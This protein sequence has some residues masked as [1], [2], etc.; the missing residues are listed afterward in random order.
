MQDEEYAINE[1]FQ[2]TALQ[3]A[4]A[5][6]LDE[7]ESARI[8][9]EALG[10]AEILGRPLLESSI[11]RFHQTRK[12][13]LDSFRLIL[14]AS[15]DVNIPESIRDVLL[16]VII[17]V[18]PQDS[19]G[20]G[21][22]F[23]SKCLQKMGEMKSMLQSLTDRLNGA[24]VLGQIQRSEFHETIEYQRAS[25]V[26]QHESLG[27]IVHYLVK[28]NHA[29]PKDFAQ[30]LDIL[31]RADKYDNLLGESRFYVIGCRV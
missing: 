6:D 8:A 15:I 28:A 19:S 3:L 14:Y 27:I 30:I 21:Q 22:S 7:I 2:Q 5:L 1:D 9:L 23:V 25:L 13:L 10:D 20:A 18:L 31:K 16:G 26:Q 12:Y 17:R 24:S 4:D 29:A 11:I